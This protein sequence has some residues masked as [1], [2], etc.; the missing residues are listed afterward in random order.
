MPPLAQATAQTHYSAVPADA[1][2]WAGLLDSLRMTG[3]QGRQL[4][5][6]A[7][8]RRPRSIAADT[9]SLATERGHALG[10]QINLPRRYVEVPVPR[11]SAATRPLL[12][13]HTVC[14][15]AALTRCPAPDVTRA[16]RRWAADRTRTRSPSTLPTT[17]AV[18]LAEAVPEALLRWHDALRG[19][20]EGWADDRLTPARNRKERP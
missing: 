12:Q 1:D 7:G 11:G 5:G 16:S 4:H 18:A 20:I 15:A 17:S 9:M 13:R 19:R 3:E 8:A 10:P 6:H 14:S 2:I